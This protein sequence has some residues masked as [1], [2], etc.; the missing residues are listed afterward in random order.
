MGMCYMIPPFRT[1]ERSK[2]SVLD[3]ILQPNLYEDLYGVYDHQVHIHY[4]K[5]RGDNKEGGTTSTSL[6]GL[7]IPCRSRSTSCV[8]IA[9]WPLR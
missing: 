1:K 5:P 6:A 8:A 3:Y 7:I 4:Y 9:F 2:L